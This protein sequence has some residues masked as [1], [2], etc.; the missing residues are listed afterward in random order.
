MFNIL[1]VIFSLNRS[2]KIFFQI[3]IDIIIITLCYFFSYYLRLDDF[4]F[5]NEKKIWL[6]LP[7]VIFFS[8]FIFFK[9]KFY[10]NIIRYLVL[11]FIKKIVIGSTFSA[12]LLYFFS[13]T[14]FFSSTFSTY[15]I[16]CSTYYIFVSYQNYYCLFVYSTSK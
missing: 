12:C 1:Q 15:Y 3:F 4:S 2:S 11:N 13:L 10:Q 9:F 5:L 8:I 16:L 14:R 7:L 6:V